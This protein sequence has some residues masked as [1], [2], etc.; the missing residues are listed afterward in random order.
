VAPLAFWTRTLFGIAF[1]LIWFRAEAAPPQALNKTITVTYNSFIPANCS[2]G[3]P[4]RY[5]RNV[6]QQIYIST[7]G[8][9]F[10]KLAGRAGNATGNRLVEPSASGIFHFSGNKIIGTF[11]VVSGASQVTVTF[12]DS[13]QN[14]SAEVINGSESGKPFVW[15]NLVGVKCTSTGKSTVSN[16]SCSV[17]QGNA[18]AN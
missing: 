16:I 6:T 13:Y 10:A 4:N 3:T 8:R 18:F 2:D 9:L 5:A 14:C 17:R 1:A 11:P 12:D 7:Q 15:V